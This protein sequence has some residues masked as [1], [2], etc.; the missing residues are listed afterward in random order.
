MDLK[1]VKEEKSALP[2]KEI[3][4]DLVYE[5]V[6]PSRLQLVQSIANKTKA[7]EALVIVKKIDTTYGD[8][9]AKVTAYIYDNEDAMSKIEYKKVIEKNTPKAPEQPADSNNQEAE[10]KTEK[11]KAEEKVEEA[12]PEEKKEEPK[13]EELKEQSQ[14]EDKKEQS[15]PSKENSVP[16]AD[17]PAA[18]NKKEGE[19]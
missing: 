1:I 14:S 13:T 10:E 12:K 5:N 3:E 9:T 6:T 17:A 18:E 8:K 11:P 4:C 15:E 16:T 2:R 19:Q 7:K